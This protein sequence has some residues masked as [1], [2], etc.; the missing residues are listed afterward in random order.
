MSS[1]SIFDKY[2]ND[3]VKRANQMIILFKEQLEE[4]EKEQKEKEPKK[5]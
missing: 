1:N 2:G 4:K 5:K 3:A